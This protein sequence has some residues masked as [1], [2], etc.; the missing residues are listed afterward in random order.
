MQDIKSEIN[1]EVVSPLAATITNASAATVVSVGVLSQMTDFISSN[2]TL[3]TTCVIVVSLVIQIVFGIM[4][5][6]HNN[7]RTNSLD[8]DERE[9][10]QDAKEALFREKEREYN[11]KSS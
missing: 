9:K 7:R 10:I 3:I 2:S 4:N 11:K 5:Q 8:L 1:H 6:Y